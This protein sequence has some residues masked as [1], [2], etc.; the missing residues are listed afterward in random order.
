MLKGDAA[1]EL[2]ARLNWR[3]MTLPF[4]AALIPLLLLAAKAQISKKDTECPWDALF[5]MACATQIQQVPTIV[6]NMLQKES[7]H[8][9]FYPKER[10]DGEELVS[11]NQSL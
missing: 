2:I 4:S 5:I 9:L 10:S 1:A 11:A 6:R 8:H 7:D 3:A